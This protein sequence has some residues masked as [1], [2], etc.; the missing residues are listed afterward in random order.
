ML[1]KQILRNRCD[2]TSP[3]W[4]WRFGLITEATGCTSALC[5]AQHKADYVDATIMLSVQRCC[6][7]KPVAMGFYEAN[8]GCCAHHNFSTLAEWSVHGKYHSRIQPR[9]PAVRRSLPHIQN[10]DDIAGRLGRHDDHLRNMRRLTEGMTPAPLATSSGDRLGTNAGIMWRSRSAPSAPDWRL[11]HC[12]G[13][14][15]T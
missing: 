5:G 15:S 10:F 7:S 4:L 12:A 9:D 6:S 3:D 13:R 14:S 8:T 1:L 2:E 11:A